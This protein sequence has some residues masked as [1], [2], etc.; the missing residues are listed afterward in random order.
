MKNLT[1]KISPAKLI[2]LQCPTCGRKH[3]EHPEFG[4]FCCSSCLQTVIRPLIVALTGCPLPP[5]Q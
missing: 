4:R 5:N 3:K 1:R 2:I